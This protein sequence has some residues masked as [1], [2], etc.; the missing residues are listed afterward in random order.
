MFGSL[1]DGSLFSMAGPSISDYIVVHI[2]A[3]KSRNLVVVQLSA[4]LATDNQA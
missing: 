1:I 3:I 4:I 2:R